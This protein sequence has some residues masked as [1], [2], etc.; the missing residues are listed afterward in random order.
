V[1]RPD[2]LFS[3]TEIAA[4]VNAMARTIASLPQRPEIMVGILAGAFVFA[5]DLARAL[6][7]EGL[8]IPVE[9]V[10]L[11]SYG[12]V[13]TG[14]E[15][16]V[17]IGPADIARGRNVLIV[18]GVLDRGATLA[19]AKDL[20]VEHGA[21]SLV[22]AVAIDKLRSDA[23]LK[24]DHAA[25]AGVNGFIVGYGMDDGGTG[26]ALPYIARVS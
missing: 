7:R 21:S 26:R 1:S 5:A 10:W 17:L 20:L 25:F 6:A 23:L 4:R 12:D 3:E 15:V 11:R 19:R 8:L 14:G 9:F 24:A 13:R 16:R 2:I 18:D 22:T